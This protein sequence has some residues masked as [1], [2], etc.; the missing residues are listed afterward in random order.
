MSKAQAEMSS[1]QNCNRLYRFSELKMSLC[2]LKPT[3]RKMG[4]GRE[5]Q[6]EKLITL[7]IEKNIVALNLLIVHVCLVKKTPTRSV[8]EYV[9]IKKETL[10]KCLKTRISL[11]SK[12]AGDFL[13]D[14][15][16]NVSMHFFLS[17]QLIF[18][19][20]VLISTHGSDSRYSFRPHLKLSEND[21]W[22]AFNTVL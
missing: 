16:L 19:L 8:N 2:C 18:S 21:V 22:Y 20:T 12:I 6:T 7:F 14:W 17:L 9:G 15:S 13:Q 11:V 3:N 5:R 1:W 10:V 4:R